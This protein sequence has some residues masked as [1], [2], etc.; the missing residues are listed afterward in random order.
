MTDDCPNDSVLGNSEKEGVE[1]LGGAAVAADDEPSADVPM[2]LREGDN[3]LESA[4]DLLAEENSKSESDVPPRNATPDYQLDDLKR[5]IT[6]MGHH[7]SKI[8]SVLG[9]H[10]CNCCDCDRSRLITG[11]DSSAG[12]SGHQLNVHPTENEGVDECQKSAEVVDGQTSPTG[13]STEQDGERKKTDDASVATENGKGHLDSQRDV[14]SND[15]Q[16]KLSDLQ[17]DVAFVGHCI[18]KIIAALALGRC[19]CRQCSRSHLRLAEDD[20]SLEK[21]SSCHEK[22]EVRTSEEAHCNLVNGAALSGNGLYDS[23][24]SAL[25]AASS[26]RL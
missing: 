18:W 7:I 9:L 3:N 26:Q 16:T 25:T 11:E 6:F 24:D 17:P 20:T 15:Q 19:D 5:D 12:P 10:R 23:G 4:A 14:R 13:T 22:E 2:E 1:K 21:N 8:V